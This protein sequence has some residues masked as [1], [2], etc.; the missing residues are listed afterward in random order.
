MQTANCVEEKEWVD[1][2]SKIC[3]SNTARL[4]N[5]HS[6]AYINGMWTWSVCNF[7]LNSFFEINRFFTYSCGIADQHATGCCAVEPNPIEMQLANTLDPARDLQRLNSLIMSNIQRLQGL[8]P[9]AG[10]VDGSEDVAQT[11]A[12]LSELTGAAL[13]LD[14]VYR[15]Y[16]EKLTRDMKYGSL[17]APIGDDN[18]LHLS[19][20]GMAAAAA[21]AVAVGAAKNQHHSSNNSVNNRSVALYNH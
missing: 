19:G 13:N 9:A 2:L 14:T 6:C 11:K 12:T 4:E 20:F 15:S 18:Y 7:F 8:C 17:Q 16:R 1:L 5:Y 21:A 3:Q 10:G